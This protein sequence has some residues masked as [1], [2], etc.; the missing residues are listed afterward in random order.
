MDNK[1]EGW[2][3]VC[4]SADPCHLFRQIRRS[5]NIF[6]QIWH[7]KHIRNQKFKGKLVNLN[8][9][10]NFAQIVKKATCLITITQ[11]NSNNSL[12]PEFKWD[13]FEKRNNLNELVN[14]PTKAEEGFMIQISLS[15]QDPN[16][17]KGTIQNPP[18]NSQLIY[19][20]LW[21]QNPRIRSIYRK[22]PQ[23]VRFLRPN[24]SIRKPIH[25]PHKNSTNGNYRLFY[26]KANAG[27]TYS[28][29]ALWLVNFCFMFLLCWALYIKSLLSVQKC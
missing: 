3:G 7:H 8:A 2:I 17:K 5:T 29:S 6:V 21:F 24:L 4:K 12:T 20:P 25:P 10:V 28:R 27:M 26:L 23:S 15:T 16:I 19:D 22:N 13:L 11:Y 18:Q 1:R 14:I 9:I